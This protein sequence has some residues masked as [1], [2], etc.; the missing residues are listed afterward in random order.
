[1]PE[2][3]ISMIPPNIWGDV[4]RIEVDLVNSSGALARLV[5][6]LESLNAHT[7]VAEA[8]VVDN[9]EKGTLSVIADLTQYSSPNDRASGDRV[10]SLRPALPDFQMR[11]G[12]EFV[13]D[14]YF[15]DGQNPRLRIRRIHSH[16]RLHQYLLDGTLTNPG[17]LR[18]QQGKMQL[19]VLL[20]HE[21]GAQLGD[22]EG[23][24]RADFLVDSKDRLIRILFSRN[25]QIH[26]YFRRYGNAAGTILTGLHEANFEIVRCRL[27][28]GLL[29]PPPELQ[30]ANASEYSTLALMVRS[31]IE[32]PDL[33]ED[34]LIKIVTAQLASMPSLA[35][36]NTVVT[37]MPSPPAPR[38]RR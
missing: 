31:T 35:G 27:V 38:A 18:I 1:M 8:A 22:G 19:P 7:V 32:H 36:C 4:W 3:V 33:S 2:L 6:L 11:I 30:G 13:K 5:S 16:Y 34:R 14:M 23:E 26:I 24:V 21:I 37:A 29:D 15:H 9:G 28:Q 25:G 17:E 10:Q 20:R 12:A